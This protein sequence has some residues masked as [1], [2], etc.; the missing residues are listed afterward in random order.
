ML[1]LM[2]NDPHINPRELAKITAPTLVICGKKDMIKES[3]TRQI[4]ES[5]PNSRLVIIK[6]NHFI[7]AENPKEF[8]N[9]VD[10]FLKGIKA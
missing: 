6:G 1:G 8:N 10:R 7:A 4:A 3:H 9:E 2:V 5:I